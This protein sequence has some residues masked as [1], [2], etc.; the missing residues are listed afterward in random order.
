MSF[1]R[2]L[3][4]SKLANLDFREKNLAKVHTIREKVLQGFSVSIVCGVTY[5]GRILL[6]ITESVAKS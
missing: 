5:T 1:K 6:G 2:F 3:R 4:R